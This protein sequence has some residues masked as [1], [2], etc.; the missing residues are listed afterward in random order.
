VRRVR[1]H[2]LPLPLPV[3]S[4][5]LTIALAPAPSPSC[6]PVRPNQLD[7]SGECPG[8]GIPSGFFETARCKPRV[9]MCT[10]AL[11]RAPAMEPHR[12]ADSRGNV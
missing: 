12:A 6:S 3:L 1:P 8:K 10:R 11:A 9:K 5:A 7:Y 4:D 2:T